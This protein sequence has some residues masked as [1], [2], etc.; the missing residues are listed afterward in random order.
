MKQNIKAVL[1]DLVG[2]LI[3]VKE[4]VGIVYSNIASGFGLMVDPKELEESFQIAIHKFPHASGGEKEERNWWKKIVYETFKLCGVDLDVDIECMELVHKTKSNKLFNNIFESLYGE[5]A[6]KSVWAIY[7]DVIPTLEKLSGV[8]AYCNTPLQIGLISNFDNRLETIL[9]E[10]DLKKYFHC[11]SY[12]GKVGFSKP[13]PRIFQF[14]LKE[15]NVL[16]EETIYIGD[17]LDSDYY[18]ALNLNINAVLINRER[19]EISPDI[20]SV[21]SLEQIFDFLEV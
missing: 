11:L 13:D 12:S 19:K 10:L 17:S 2:T 15:L 18:P 14:A 16:P 21:S 8:G 7:P 9:N 3:Y 1:F 4:S 20:K 5:F 6:K